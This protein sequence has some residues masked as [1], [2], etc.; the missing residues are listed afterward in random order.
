L[1]LEQDLFKNNESQIE[2]DFFGD[3]TKE[4][5]EYAV[6]SPDPPALDFNGGRWIAPL[7][8]PAIDHD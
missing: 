5:S 3:V 7:T 1:T 8:S 4:A 2:T 6:E